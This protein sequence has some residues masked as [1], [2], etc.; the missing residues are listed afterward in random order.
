MMRRKNLNA[1][2]TTEG[3]NNYYLSRSLPHVLLMHPVLKFLVELMEEGKLEKWLDKLPTD[4]VGNVVL[5]NGAKTSRENIQYYYRY[6]KFL[7]GNNAFAGMEKSEMNGAMFSPED[8]KIALA[9]TSQVVFEVTESCNLNCKYCGFGDFY[10]GFSKRRKRNLTLD[11]ARKFLD[12]MVEL[13]ESPL[14]RKF[15]KKIAL[16]FYGGDALEN[17]PF[18]EEMVHYARLK[19]LTHKKFF[20]SMTTNGVLLDQHMDFLAANDFVLLISLDGNERHN[21][22]RVFPNGDSS[23]KVVYDNILKLQARHPDYFRRSVNFLSVIHDKNFN[24]K[25]V[26]NFFWEKFSKA[27][28]FNE[29]NQLGIKPDKKAELQ[30]QFRGAHSAYTAE[31]L[32]EDTGDK[33][34]ILK[35]PITNTLFGTLS[36]YSG[37]VFKKYD[38]LT[39]GS[40]IPWSVRTGTCNPFEKKVFVTTEGKILPCE[41]ILHDYSMGSVDKGGIHLDFE[42]IAEKYNRFYQ[43]LMDSCNRCATSDSCLVCMFNLELGKKNPHCENYMK[44]KDFRNELSQQLSLLEAAPQY[45]TQIMKNYKVN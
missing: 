26:N 2:I 39:S 43:N 31:D 8:I 5:N 27:P 6:L 25:E 29:L 28:I 34:K 10:S 21:G 3:R 15:H 17:I 32:S 44:D 18:L 7:E 33:L 38:S 19:K 24:R 1:L 16:S 4:E 11:V 14:N 35:S 20:F 12:F 45:Y 41:K 22:Y 37:F 23:F 36:R 42:K 13:F 30:T 40:T 9:N